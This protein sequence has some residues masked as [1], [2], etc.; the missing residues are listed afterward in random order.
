MFRE[1]IAVLLMAF[2]GAPVGISSIS[3]GGPMQYEYVTKANIGEAGHRRQVEVMVEASS[4]SEAR[5]LFDNRYGRGNWNT[6]IQRKG[7]VR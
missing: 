7:P 2:Y 5:A 4:D 1:P 3:A 6:S